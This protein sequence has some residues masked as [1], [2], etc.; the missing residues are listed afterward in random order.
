MLVFYSN[1]TGQKFNSAK[2]FRI[3][4]PW[5]LDIETSWEISETLSEVLEKK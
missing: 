3:V 4:R 1:K 5:L 2:I